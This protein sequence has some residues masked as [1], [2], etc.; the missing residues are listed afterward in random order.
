LLSHW[1]FSPILKFWVFFNAL[2]FV[3]IEKKT[4]K[5][6]FFQL[7]KLDPQNALYESRIDIHHKSLLL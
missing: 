2:G 4:T 7:E 3:Y 6:V 5:F 1:A